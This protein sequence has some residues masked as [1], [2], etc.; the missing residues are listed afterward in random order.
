MIPGADRVGV[1]RTE[2]TGPEFGQPRKDLRCIRVFARVPVREGQALHA[3]QCVRV[4][5]PQHAL[6]EFERL[7]MEPHSVA[8]S[9]L[10]G[11]GIGQRNP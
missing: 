4:I 6:P 11:T 9:S 5:L 3:G 2:G 10:A 1:I 7:F 8:V